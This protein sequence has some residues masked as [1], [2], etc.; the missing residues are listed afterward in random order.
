[1]L[2]KNTTTE[3]FTKDYVARL[4]SQDF[5]AQKSQTNIK[6]PL[7]FEQNIS[8]QQRPAEQQ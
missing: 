7:A 2:R 5:I 1:M 8:M 6:P 4:M 3:Y